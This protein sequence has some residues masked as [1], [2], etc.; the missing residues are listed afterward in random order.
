MLT[1]TNYGVVCLVCLTT[2]IF[3]LIYFQSFAFHYILDYGK[4][5]Q[6]KKTTPKRKTIYELHHK[7]FFYCIIPIYQ[8]TLPVYSSTRH[9]LRHQDEH[10]IL[11]Y[12]VTKTSFISKNCVSCYFEHWRLS[13]RIVSVTILTFV[14][15]SSEKNQWL[16]NEKKKLTFLFPTVVP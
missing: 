15:F 13:F 2:R 8:K 14:W 7:M 12:K 1:R 6:K 10:L 4:K 5:Q 3:I 16:S 9:I 11:F